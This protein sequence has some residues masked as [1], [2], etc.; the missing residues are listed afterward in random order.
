MKIFVNL[1]NFIFLESSISGLDSTGRNGCQGLKNLKSTVLDG[2]HDHINFDP[3]YDD[4]ANDLI[5]LKLFVCSVA[6]VATLS[7]ILI[8]I[9]FLKTLY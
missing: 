5:N 2:F 9:H 1:A 8:Y 7:L 3:E 4:S 6:F